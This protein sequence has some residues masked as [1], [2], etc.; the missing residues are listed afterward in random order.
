MAL[1]RTILGLIIVVILFH[2]G[3]FYVGVARDTNGLTEAIY[4]L[5]ELLESPMQA[6]IEYLPLTAEQRNTGGANG[7]YVTSLGA[8]AGYFILYFLLGIGRRD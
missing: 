7:F 1:I 3:M 6:I 2:V 5:A 4:G 8:A